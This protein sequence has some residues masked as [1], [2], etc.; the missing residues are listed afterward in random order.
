MARLRFGRIVFGIC[1]LMLAVLPGMAAAQSASTFIVPFDRTG[2]P[3]VDTLLNPTGAFDNPCTG[4]WV[5]VT[6]SS[7]VTI[8]QTAKD[9]KG[10]FKITVSVTSR[11][12]G[13]GWMPPA[14][15]DPLVPPDAGAYTDRILTGSTY[16]FTENQKFTATVPYLLATEYFN[17]TFSD[18]FGLK[19]QG[20]TDNWVI[21][22]FFRVKISGT[23]TVQVFIDRMN[24][25]VCKG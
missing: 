9:N 2:A 5:D 25:D 3:G 19:G 7:S 6:G 4:E 15:W 13:T 10:E 20:P 17:S 21:R 18:K 24:G 14:L 23:G 11:G 12:S 1:A 8:N 16:V 22:A